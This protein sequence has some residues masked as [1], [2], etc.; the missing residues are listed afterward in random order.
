MAHDLAEKYVKEHKNDTDL[1]KAFE[2][3]YWACT[4]NWCKKT[5]IKL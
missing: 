5:K 4:D 3:G 2:A 1:A